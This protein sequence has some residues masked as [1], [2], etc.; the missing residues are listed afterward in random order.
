MLTS[1]HTCIEH[2]ICLL[3]ILQICN[4]LNHCL[5]TIDAPQVFWRL[6]AVPADKIQH[7]AARTTIESHRQG[8]PGRH[9]RGRTSSCS[10]T[11]HVRPD[12][13]RS[14]QLLRRSIPDIDGPLCMMHHQ[15]HVC[16]IVY[17]H[18]YIYINLYTHVKHTSTPPAGLGDPERSNGA[19]IFEIIGPEHECRLVQPVHPDRQI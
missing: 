4:T 3:C 10:P 15:S 8:T 11:R 6:F 7:V 13:L 18:I 17:I 16:H 12:Q 14:R 19:Q 9:N 1:C 5:C 2:S